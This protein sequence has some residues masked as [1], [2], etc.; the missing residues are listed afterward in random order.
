MSDKQSDKPA[1]SGDDTDLTE[2]EIATRF[3]STVR[4]M[5]NT[6]PTIKAAKADDL[7]VAETIRAA[8]IRIKRGDDGI[9][10]LQSQGMETQRIVRESKKK[11][12]PE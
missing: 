1:Q 11:V 12:A 9:A 4:R 8:R 6:P 7:A 5:A 3:E 2:A 10:E